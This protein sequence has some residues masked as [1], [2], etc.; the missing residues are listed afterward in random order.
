MNP[1]KLQK[2]MD[3]IISFLNPICKFR[4]RLKGY[5]HKERDIMIFY[6]LDPGFNYLVNVN[7]IYT[8]NT[9]T[10][11][12]GMFSPIKNLLDDDIKKYLKEALM[13]A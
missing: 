11:E 8:L 6:D 10:M 7:A 4:Y 12:P 1:K 9:V 13:S 3:K 2:A 5:Y